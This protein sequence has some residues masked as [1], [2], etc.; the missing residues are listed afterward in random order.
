MGGSFTLSHTFQI[1]DAKMKKEIHL[2][3]VIFL[4][5]LNVTTVIYF[6]PFANSVH[7]WKE[8][9]TRRKENFKHRTITA[10]SPGKAVVN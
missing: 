6:V 7:N 10:E 4:P 3:I 2:T 8:E 5:N 9:E 1:W